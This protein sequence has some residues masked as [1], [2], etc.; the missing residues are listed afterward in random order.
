MVVV[1]VGLAVLAAIAEKYYCY[2]CYLDVLHVA[3]VQYVEHA[4]GALDV[5]DGLDVSNVM[6]VSGVLFVALGLVVMECVALEYYYS[7]HLVVMTLVGWDA[8]NALNLFEIVFD[9]DYLCWDQLDKMAVIE[10]FVVIE[11]LLA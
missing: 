3:D 9:Y 5:W 2:H 8:L 4:L 6:D 10:V 11:V 1:F 7:M